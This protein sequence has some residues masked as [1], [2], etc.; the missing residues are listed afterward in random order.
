MDFQIWVKGVNE[1][2]E[3]PANAKRSVPD[4]MAAVGQKLRDRWLKE[5]SEKLKKNR[6]AAA[7]PQP[8]PGT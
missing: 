4:G 7:S 5:W 8:S 3:D 6:E 1:F 2:Y